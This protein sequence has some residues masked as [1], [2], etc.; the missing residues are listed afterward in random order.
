MDGN[1][2]AV[3]SLAKRLDRIERHNRG[4]R[5]ALLACAAAAA[6]AFVAG[7]SFR[8][9]AG[10]GGKAVH[11]RQ[12]EAEQIVIRDADGQMRAWMGVA[13]GGPRLLFFDNAGQQ[14]VGVGLSAQ[15]EPSF[16]IFDGGQN[17]RVVLGMVDGW[18]GLVFRDPSG[19]QRIAMHTQ[20]GWAS[21]IF[22]DRDEVRRSGIGAFEK[23]AAVNLCD[24]RG[25]ERV[26]L[27]L[28]ATAAS[29]SFFDS[30]KQ[31]RLGL[32]IVRDDEP[33][34]GFFDDLGRPRAVLTSAAD[35]SDFSLYGTNGVQAT[36][37][38]SAAG[39]RMQ[40]LGT[41]GK[42]TWKAP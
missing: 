36:V 20:E 11:Q 12:V 30:K 37:S 35:K 19:K 3:R 5:L 32:G 34:L 33:A 4:L 24:D 2:E 10:A 27:T 18:P 41:D 22:C 15:A 25:R 6:G 16:G 13:E 38:S 40:L 31:K 28:E 26:G 21:L 7:Y 39:P 8:D 1:A 14:R 42:P 29:L 17:P 9:D 23:G